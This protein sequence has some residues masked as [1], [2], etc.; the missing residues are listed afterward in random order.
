[1]E[2]RG[3]QLGLGVEGDLEVS[4]G[5]CRSPTLVKRPLHSSVAMGRYG[6]HL[7]RGGECVELCLKDSVP[8]LL[9]LHTVFDAQVHPEVGSVLC[10]IGF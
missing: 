9:G 6:R 4:L 10:I 7:S 8:R 1:M 5:A 2:A 3:S